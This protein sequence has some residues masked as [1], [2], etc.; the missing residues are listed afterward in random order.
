MCIYAV[1]TW[2]VFSLHS[3]DITQNTNALCTKRVVFGVS[4]YYLQV[5]KG[6]QRRPLRRERSTQLIVV[7]IT[8]QIERKNISNE[9]LLQ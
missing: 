3:N 6:A 1:D 2:N 8:A 5:P 7:E 9:Q 4:P